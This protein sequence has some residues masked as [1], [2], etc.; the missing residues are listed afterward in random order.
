M[1]ATVVNKKRKMTALDA[2]AWR[3]FSAPLSFLT[4]TLLPGVHFRPH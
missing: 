1:P 3:L 4:V 2:A